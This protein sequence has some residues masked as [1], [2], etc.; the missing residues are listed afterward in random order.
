MVNGINRTWASKEEN[1]DF[2]DISSPSSELSINEK[3]GKRRL[4]EIL[5]TDNKNVSESPKKIKNETIVTISHVPNEIICHI[6]S[7]L[8]IGNLGNVTSV[9][10]LTGRCFR[11]LASSRGFLL[12]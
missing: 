12:A 3:N 9:S 8:D 10:K 4:S 6:L 11:W 7:F 1:L 2:M 5:D